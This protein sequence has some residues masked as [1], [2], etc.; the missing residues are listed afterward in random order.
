LKSLQLH[1]GFQMWW[2]TWMDQ[3]HF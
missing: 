2:C 3:N 1:Q